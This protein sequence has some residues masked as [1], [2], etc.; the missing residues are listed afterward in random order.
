MYL[1]DP[2]VLRFR[3]PAKNN[4]LNDLVEFLFASLEN[5]DLP[6]PF[7]RLL[8]ACI[9]TTTFMSCINRI[10]SL[11]GIFLW[12]GTIEGHHTARVSWETVTLTKDQ[13]GL[14]VKD[15]HSWNLACI[16]KLIW[17]LFF[18]PK[19]VWVC[20]FK[21]VILRGD[22]SNYWTINPSVNYSWLI[23]KMLKARDFIYL[24]LKQRIGNGES[25]R[26]WFD[27]WSPFGNLYTFLNANSTRLGI[28][29]TTTVA[30]LFIGGRWRLP[31]ARTENQLT[32]HVHL[33][34]VVFS[35]MEDQYEWSIDGRLRKRYNTSEIYTYLK[36]QCQQVPWA[37]IVWFSYG[38]PRHN[39]FMTWLV[40][41]DRCPTKVMLNRWVLNVDPLCLL[42]STD[43]ESMNHIF[44]ECRYSETV[45][46]KITEHCDLPALTSWEDTVLQ[47]QALRT[48]R[49]TLRLIL[50]ATQ[51]T[52][53]W[54][55]SE[56]NARLHQHIFK[57]PEALISLIDEQIRNRLQSFRH[58][59]PRASSAMTQLW[60]LRS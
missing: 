45:W 60:F 40:L 5:L 10:N 3:F 29:K 51:A 24:L 6:A 35:D 22:I 39:N 32:L 54:L 19:F 58:A 8:K 17:M 49:D 33:T 55:W 56:R 21:E 41:L 50:L 11:C 53:Y 9:C 27:N 13:G 48:N 44:S 47:L 30:S 46:R 1:L 4:K 37:K 16:L 28:P 42:C 43:H 23:N 7:T 2:R 52:I 26:F 12:K 18:R 59:N 15:C 31:P 34:T 20:W 36:G 57:Q 14:G 25:T 38:I